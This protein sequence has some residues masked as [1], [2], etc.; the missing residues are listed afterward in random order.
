[1]TA[2]VDP[3]QCIAAEALLYCTLA[4]IDPASGQVR[5]QRVESAPYRD[6]CERRDAFAAARSVFTAAYKEAQRTAVGRRTWPQLGLSLQPPVDAAH[7]R[8]R[9]VGTAQFEQAEA[10]LERAATQRRQGHP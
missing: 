6:Y 4:V 5:S 3:Q 8:L 7:E 9:R 1:M 2:L 10:L